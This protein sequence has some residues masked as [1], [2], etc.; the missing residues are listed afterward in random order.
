M[1]PSEYCKAQ[2]GYKNI[3]SSDFI[4]GYVMNIE[5]LGLAIYEYKNL[6]GNKKMILGILFCIF[7]LLDDDRD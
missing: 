6:G 5:C 3:K 7:L 1:K 4:E 2:L